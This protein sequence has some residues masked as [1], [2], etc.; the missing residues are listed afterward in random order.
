MN[1][2][3]AAKDILASCLFV[4]REKI[5]D[6]VNIDAIAELDSLTFEMIVLEIEKHTGREVDPMRMLDM[7]TVRDLAD[8]LEQPR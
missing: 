5:A 3:D 8:L 6:D 7:R 1:A 4:P 2:L